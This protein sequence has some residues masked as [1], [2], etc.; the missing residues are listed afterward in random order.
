MVPPLLVPEAAHLHIGSADVDLC[1]SV[2]I[3]D[4]ATREYNRSGQA[5]HTVTHVGLLARRAHQEET[6]SR[7]DQALAASGRGQLA[8]APRHLPQSA[9]A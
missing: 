3:T 2:A 7:L 4:G 5:M 6:D 9:E 1:L 8:Y